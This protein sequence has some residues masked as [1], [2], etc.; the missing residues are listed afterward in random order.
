ME[1][2]EFD[3]INLESYNNRGHTPIIMVERGNCHFV[4][5]A[6]NAQKFGAAMLLVIDNK[7]EENPKNL[8]MADDGMGSSVYIPSFII[9]KSDGESLKKAV[10]SWEHSKKNH[11][12]S[13]RQKRVVIQADISVA[14]KTKGMIDVD[15][16]YTGAYEFRTAGWDFKDLAEMQDIFSHRIAFEPRAI[17]NRCNKGLCSKEEKNTLCINDGKYCPVYPS[18]IENLDNGDSLPMNLIMQSIRE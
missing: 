12:D 14:T 13:A 5:K 3:I 16:W 6:Q 4:Q 15:L 1:D 2:F 10:T 7:W 18:N 11:D 9:K 8:V 17:I